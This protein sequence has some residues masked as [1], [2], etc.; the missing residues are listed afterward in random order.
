MQ[1]SPQDGVSVG[2]GNLNGK[3]FL[4]RQAQLNHIKRVQTKVLNEVR[5]GFD[6]IGVDLHARA[7]HNSSA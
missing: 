7:P 3:L 5:V 2:V 6:G 1:R 4:Q